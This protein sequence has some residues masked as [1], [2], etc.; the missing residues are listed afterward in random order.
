MVEAVLRE[1]G[2]TR[3]KAVKARWAVIRS[4]GSA[5]VRTVLRR[6]EKGVV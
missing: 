2:V 4:V 5:A 6:R 1:E 3:E